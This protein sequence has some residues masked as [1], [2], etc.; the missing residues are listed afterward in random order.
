MERLAEVKLGNPADEKITMGPLATA[1]Q[2]RDVRAGIARLAAVYET[3]C[4]GAEAAWRAWRRAPS[5]RR[6]CS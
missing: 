6:R 5:S 3:A 4:G 1:Q 2:Q